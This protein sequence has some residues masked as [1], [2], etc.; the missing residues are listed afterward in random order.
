MSCVRISA[1]A[2]DLFLKLWYVMLSIRVHVRCTF[3]VGLVVVVLRVSGET[4]VTFMSLFRKCSSVCFRLSSCRRFGVHMR[5]SV[6]CAC[7]C[8]FM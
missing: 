1:F 6:K 5:H 7:S 3:V 8:N 2:G 4:S